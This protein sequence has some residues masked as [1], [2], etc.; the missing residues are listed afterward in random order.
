MSP[1][2]IC[3]CQL[4]SFDQGLT[5]MGF[6]C[7][8]NQLREKLTF[9]IITGI[10]C[11]SCTNRYVIQIAEKHADNFYLYIVEIVEK[12]SQTFNKQGEH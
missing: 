10:V 1:V 12:P 6:F 2:T 3:V 7:K 8:S 9:N 11:Y 4:S 5:L